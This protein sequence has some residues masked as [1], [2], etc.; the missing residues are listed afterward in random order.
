[1]STQVRQIWQQ[2]AALYDRIYAGNVPYHR[3]HEVIVDLLPKDRPIRVLDLGAGTG[4]LAMR[5]LDSLPDSFVTCLDFSTAMI[6]ESTRKLGRFG[7]RADFVCADIAEWPA[8]SEYDAVVACNALVYRGMDL[9]L[10]YKRCAAQLSGGGL[11]I[12]STV[13]ECPPVVE[14][15][16]VMSN[17]RMPRA[18]DMPPEAYEFARTVGRE[19]AHFG[20]DSLA[21]VMSADMHLELM[22]KAGLNASC[23]WHYVTQAVLLGQKTQTDANQPPAGR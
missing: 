13:V 19:I 23:P 3:S 9:G 12:N 7:Q 18:A 16:A 14:L 17:F 1:M 21:F 22:R 15:S 8:P 11:F 2:G 4:S 20:E 6:A 10:V 5:I